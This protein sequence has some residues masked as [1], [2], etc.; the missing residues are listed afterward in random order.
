M[1]IKKT[2]ILSLGILFLISFVSVSCSSPKR[3]VRK[4]AQEFLDAYYTH[5]YEATRGISTYTTQKLVDKKAYY[6]SLNPNA[7][8]NVDLKI[9]ETLLLKEKKRAIVKYV[10]NGKKRQIYLS[11]SLNLP[12]LVDMDEKHPIEIM[13][14]PQQQKATAED[15]GVSSVEGEPTKIGDVK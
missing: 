15:S 14:G 8:V 5:N 11:K 3:E 1:N 10:Y 7:K 9:T 2:K 12:W 4:T 6:Y 13:L